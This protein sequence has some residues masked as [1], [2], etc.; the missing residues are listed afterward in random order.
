MA[1]YDR[2]TDKAPPMAV[3]EVVDNDDPKGINR[4]MVEI[5]GIGKVGWCRPLSKGGH[6]EDADSQS[7]PIGANAAVFFNFGDWDDPYYMSA[8]QNPDQMPEETTTEDGSKT[9]DPNVKC[10]VIGNYRITVDTREGSNS[11][12]VEDTK[13]PNLFVMDTDQNSIYIQALT[14]VRIK[15]AAIH[16]DAPVVAVKERQISTTGNSPI[17]G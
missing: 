6:A 2:E 16:L 12:V 17:N 11:I 14:T 8:G 1:G 4:V 15:A 9:G 5:Q 3:G 10:R 7:P 13:S